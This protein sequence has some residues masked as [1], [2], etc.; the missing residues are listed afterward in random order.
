MS[1]LWCQCPP[2]KSTTK[3]RAP[4]QLGSL[5]VSPNYAVGSE[6]TGAVV[7][8]PDGRNEHFVLAKNEW[9]FPKIDDLP[10]AMECEYF[11][12]EIERAFS[13][14]SNDWG[15]ALLP[16]ASALCEFDALII[17][18]HHASHALPLHAVRVGEGD[19]DCLGTK[20]GVSYCSSAT[21]LRR[22]MLRNRQRPT[23]P[24]PSLLR[25]LVARPQW[26]KWYVF[27]GVIPRAIR[28]QSRACRLAVV[29]LWAPARTCSN[30]AG[31]K[32]LT[33]FER[34]MTC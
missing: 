21:L 8:S 4:R 17:I 20:F 14:F 2:S 15:R 19:F 7:I 9:L 18:P 32:M 27:T 29:V 30:S 1:G 31:F 33:G 12:R 16:P 34:H 3:S 25:S 5:C 22:C 24:M 13:H 26:A 11:E 10:A 28:L 6:T 23:T